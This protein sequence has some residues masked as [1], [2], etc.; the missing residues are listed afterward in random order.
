[1]IRPLFFFLPAFLFVFLNSSKA[2]VSP[3]LSTTWNQT[4]DYNA[5]CPTVASGGACGRAYT[6]C[7]ATAIAQIC[8]FYNY[9]ITGLGNH[10]NTND[11]TH[12]VDFSTQIY[13][14]SSMPNNVTSAN[15][16]VA[17][18][19]YHA[20]I[21]TDM[22]WGGASSVSFFGSTPLKRYFAYSPKMY[23][24][25]IFLFNTT[26]ELIDA[27]KGELDEG[28][29]VY[30]KTNSINHF[31]IID[32]YDASDNFHCNFGW[33]G[34]YDG[35]YPIDNVN[36]PPGNAS[37]HNFI[38]NLRPL[39]GDL[40]IADDTIEVSANSGLENIE[41]TSLEDWTMTTPN[42]WINLNQSSGLKGYFANGDGMSFNH[43]VNNDTTRYGYVLIDNGNDVDT[44]VVKQAA[45]SLVVNPDTL[46]F[47]DTGGSQD[48]FIEWLNWSNWSATSSDAWITL[49]ENSGT[50]DDTITVTTTNNSSSSTILGHVIINGGSFTD[51]IFIEQEGQQNAGI[52]DTELDLSVRVFPNPTS[53]VLMVNSN[54]LPE[55][56]HIYDNTGKR[57]KSTTFTG[58]PI[59]VSELSDGMYFIEL[60]LNGQSFERLKFIKQ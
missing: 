19:M 57:V 22:Q 33:G 18:L 27:V 43:D 24:S 48:V 1:M 17:L 23:N 34:V 26:Q 21:A 9:P 7:N 36:I 4:C 32:G 28:R 35:Y 31:Y 56:L 6:G 50:G 20:G 49:S 46:Y 38:F 2:Q 42:S 59:D 58:V 5:D 10:C 15:A 39:D 12:C 13:D 14:Y 25:A 40:E 30:V 45:S 41:F 60:K 44:L 29:I 16:E 55:V 3:L 52:S 51:T 8:K 54:V 11:M 47:S 53:G 37:P